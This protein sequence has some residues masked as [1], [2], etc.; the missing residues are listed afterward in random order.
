MLKNVWGQVVVV[1]LTF[2]AIAALSIADG[3]AE[4]E[5]ALSYGRAAIA[6]VMAAVVL[7]RLVRMARSTPPIPPNRSL[8]VLAAVELGFVAAAV[9]GLATGSAVVDGPV[10]VLLGLF[11]L[12]VHGTFAG[13]LATRPVEETP[14]AGR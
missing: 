8:V 3:R 10:P 6:G 4:Q 9:L 13:G 2:L 7:Q 5:L 12:A 11:L 14:P 1:I